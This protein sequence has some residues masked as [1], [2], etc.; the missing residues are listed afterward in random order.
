MKINNKAF[1]GLECC[2]KFSSQHASFYAYT[3]NEF[4]I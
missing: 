4:V 1:Q 3:E 2:K